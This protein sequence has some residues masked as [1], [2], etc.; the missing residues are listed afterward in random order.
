MT[1]PAASLEPRHGAVS[2][3][4]AS[5]S[6]SSGNRLLAASRNDGT[7]GNPVLKSSRIKS[8][9]TPTRVPP[10]NT[11]T[12][13]YRWLKCVS[14]VRYALASLP[15]FTASPTVLCRFLT[16]SSSIPSS[17]AAAAMSLLA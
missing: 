10:L 15:T 8:N 9:A 16:A 4:G 12:F 13:G 7:L 3:S 11:G 1:P 6:S 17:P 14:T 5:G 2:V